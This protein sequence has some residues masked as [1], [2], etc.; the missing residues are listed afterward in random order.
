MA[1]INR[2]TEDEA[3][4]HGFT[5]GQIAKSRT[6]EDGYLGEE[7]GVMCFNTQ[8]QIKMGD[9]ENKGRTFNITDQQGDKGSRPDRRPTGTP[10]IQK[11]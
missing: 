6:T 11:P 1:N 2:Y 5:E 9:F 8:V 7:N 10:P 4:E 3:R